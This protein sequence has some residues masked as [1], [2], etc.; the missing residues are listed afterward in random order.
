MKIIRF[1]LDL[2][3]PYRQKISINQFEAEDVVFEITL[4]QGAQL[5]DLT[6]LTVTLNAIK[7]DGHKIYNACVPD[8]DPTTGKIRYAVTTQTSAAAGELTC[9]I[10][11]TS[12]TGN[13]ST[14]EFKVAV[15]PSIDNTDAVESTDEF[16]E[17]QEAIMTLTAYNARLGAAEAAIVTLDGRMDTAE[18]NITLLTC[19]VIT[20][21]IKEWPYNRLPPCGGWLWTDTEYSRATYPNLFDWLCYPIGTVTISIA[22]PGVVTKTSHGL[23]TGDQ[24]YLTTSGALPTGLTAETLY[25]VIYVN[26]NTFRLATSRVNAFSGT[27]INT[28]GSQSGAHT[29][30]DCPHGNGNGSTTFNTPARAGRSPIGQSVSDN[31]FKNIG[32]LGGEKTHLL[33]ASESGI[34]AHVHPPSSGNIVLYDNSQGDYA[35]TSGGAKLYTSNSTGS[36]TAA[37]A[38]DSHNTL[39]PYAV[40]KYIIKT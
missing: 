37:N 28:S 40:T 4:K 22:S 2:I 33:T 3:E 35:G 38:V 27:A 20:G 8:V 26:A 34:R 32:K 15:N 25:Y 36:N 17:L 19:G 24:V 30:R 31:D 9:Q 5:V 18:A 39:H 13:A 10:E 7:P 11:L 12:G 23:N 1:T 29:L 6:G 21:D 16:T 14:P